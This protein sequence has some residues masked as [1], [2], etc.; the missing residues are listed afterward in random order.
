MNP[1]MFF[2]HLHVLPP[3]QPPVSVEEK[4]MIKQW[5]KKN[6]FNRF[7]DP[8]GTHYTGG[9]PLFNET[10]GATTNRYEYIFAHHPDHPWLKTAAPMMG[11]VPASPL[12]LAAE[13]A[14]EKDASA[15]TQDSQQRGQMTEP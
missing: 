12:N 8:K 9:T 11:M 13:K 5:L 15:S 7:G 3:N 10:T 6:K 1:L 2:L 4:V 14:A